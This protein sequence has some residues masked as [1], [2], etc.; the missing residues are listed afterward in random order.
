MKRRLNARGRRVGSGPLSLRGGRHSEFKSLP[1]SLG[2]PRTQ[3]SKSQLT[4]GSASLCRRATPFPLGVFGAEQIQKQNLHRA[5]FSCTGSRCLSFGESMAPPFV[6]ADTPSFYCPLQAQGRL[7]QISS[8]N[9]SLPAKNSP[10]CSVIL[11][12]E[13]R[14]GSDPI[15]EELAVAVR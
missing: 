11:R 12:S 6:N 4:R 10:R 3:S 15:K 8:K 7:Q 5:L 14:V 9:E 1:C 2:A 13:R